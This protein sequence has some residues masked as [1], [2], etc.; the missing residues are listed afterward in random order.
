MDPRDEVVG[1]RPEGF[2]ARI[3]EHRS[4]DRSNDDEQDDGATGHP[5]ILPRAG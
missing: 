4:R 5:A 1:L 2:H 3:G